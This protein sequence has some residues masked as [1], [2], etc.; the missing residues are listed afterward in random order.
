MFR[1]LGPIDVIAAHVLV[2]WPLETNKVSD[3]TQSQSSYLNLLTG[4]GVR[5]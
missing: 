4:Q 1:L 5:I 3:I 2:V